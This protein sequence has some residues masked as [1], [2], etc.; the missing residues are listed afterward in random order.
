MRWF[1]RLVRDDSGQDVIE[2]A[3][4]AAAISVIAIPIIPAI[5]TTVLNVWTSI[6]TKVSS[7]PGA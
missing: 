7:L 4:I 3:L 1:T 2:Y 5:G 6:S